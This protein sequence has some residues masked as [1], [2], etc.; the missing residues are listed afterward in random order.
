LGTDLSDAALQQAREGCYNEFE[1]SRGLPAR[2]RNKYFRRR[3]DLWQASDQLRAMVNFRK[4][5]LA[6]QW[7]PLPM[8]DVVLLRNVMVYFQASTSR[9]ILARVRGRLK[10]GGYLFLGGAETTLHLDP[11]FT[12][13]RH[14]GFSYYQ[15]PET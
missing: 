14:A 7:P 9:Q 12:R 15:L 8:M 6:T 11:V 1:I 2:L 10:P 13:L 3:G 4:L 5:N